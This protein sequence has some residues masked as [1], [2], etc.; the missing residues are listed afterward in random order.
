MDEKIKKLIA[1]T[2]RQQELVE[3]LREVLHELDESHVTLF[4]DEECGSIFA[5][6]NKHIADEM[7]DYHNELDGYTRVDFWEYR[8]GRVWSDITSTGCDDKYFVIFE[9]DKNLF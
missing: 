1:L 4:N 2:P 8:D 3:R 7:L 5:F 6:N 9:Q